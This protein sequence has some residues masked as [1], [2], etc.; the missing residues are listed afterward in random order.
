[1]KIENAIKINFASQMNKCCRRTRKQ[2]DARY[3]FSIVH[4]IKSVAKGESQVEGAEILNQN[5]LLLK[6]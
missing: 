2:T 6:F 3:E 5:L 4:V 1:M